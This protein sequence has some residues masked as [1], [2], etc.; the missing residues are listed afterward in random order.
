MAI[1]IPSKKIFNIDNPKVRNNAIDEVRVERTLVNTNVLKI[2]ENV[3]NEDI[4]TDLAVVELSDY[5]DEDSDIKTYGI[6]RNYAFVRCDKKK[7]FS[8]TDGGGYQLDI[9]ISQ[10]KKYIY[11]IYGGADDNGNPNIRC[12]IVGVIEKGTITGDYADALTYSEPTEISAPQV[13]SFPKSIVYNVRELQEA[14]TAKAIVN[15]TSPFQIGLED[16]EIVKTTNY[17]RLS[18]PIMCGLR[19]SKFGGSDR[20]ALDT[21]LPPPPLTL[22]GTYETYVPKEINISLM[23]DTIGIELSTG[24]ITYKSENSNGETPIS[25]DGNE[26]MQ[27]SA[28]ANGK[29]LTKDLADNIFAQ[30]ENGKETISLSCAIG[31]YYSHDNG[32]LEISTKQSDIFTDRYEWKYEAVYSD[33]STIIAYDN[34]VEVTKKY[35]YDIVIEG[36]LYS[37][38]E[39]IGEHTLTI[40]KNSLE[41]ERIRLYIASEQ[42]F[43]TT[44][45]YK[46]IPMS[47]SS[48]DMIIPMK[49]NEL[50]ADIP[51]SVYA[52]G[53]PKVFEVINENI[54]YDGAILQ[55]LKAQEVAQQ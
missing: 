50:G 4:Y 40:P 10:N 12:E 46:L 31:E 35:P 27:N 24:N 34:W 5:V 2:G 22:N 54:T 16:V 26:L 33:A 14:G 32:A 51:I 23:G 52:D 45:I 13:L 17:F 55:T 8:N 15:I 39:P 42:S 6:Y 18:I 25:L 9:P 36:V 7:V 3:Y 47:F 37:G 21:T 11:N 28:T 41:S 43:R 1:I 20:F 29:L 49:R 44:A 48:G 53:S 38:D 30:Y 19:I